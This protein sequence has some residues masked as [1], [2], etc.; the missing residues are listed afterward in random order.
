MVRNGELAAN[1]KECVLLSA[2]LEQFHCLVDHFV[3]N[4]CISIILK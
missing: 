1:M 4:G 2:M 3:L